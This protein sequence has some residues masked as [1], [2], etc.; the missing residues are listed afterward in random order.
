MLD[1][2]KPLSHD[3]PHSIVL[4]YNV[5]KL[6]VLGGGDFGKRRGVDGKMWGMRVDKGNKW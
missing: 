5:G 1:M 2:D 3:D 4:L 6:S